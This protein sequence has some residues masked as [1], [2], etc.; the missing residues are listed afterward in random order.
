MQVNN[1]TSPNF[2]ALKVTNNSITKKAL[3]NLSKNN[4]EEIKK[5]GDR[6]RATK[7]FDIVLAGTGV[8]R[9][10]IHLRQQPCGIAGQGG[11]H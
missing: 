10:L 11:A 5:V 3:Q 9:Q 8:L 7:F 2:R 6:L 1:S 4:L